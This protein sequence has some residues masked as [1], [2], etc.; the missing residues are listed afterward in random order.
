MHVQCKYA[1]ILTPEMATPKLHP[2]K[3][4][5]FLINVI[6]K[7]LTDKIGHPKLESGN[8]GTPSEV[9]ITAPQC[10]HVHVVHVG[11]HHSHTFFITIS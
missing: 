11:G 6:I 2:H 5:Q 8:S 9:L 10:T 7:D 1:A 4:K 3:K